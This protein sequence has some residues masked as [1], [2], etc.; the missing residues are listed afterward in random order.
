MTEKRKEIKTSDSKAN[1]KEHEG[2]PVD[3]VDIMK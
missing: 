2:R 1:I 3:R